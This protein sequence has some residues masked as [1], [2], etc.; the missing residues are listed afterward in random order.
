MKCWFDRHKS[1]IFWFYRYGVDVEIWAHEH[2]YERFW[3]LY[4][5][6]VKNGST[7]HPYTNPKAPIHI[8]TGA[9]GNKEGRAPFKIKVPAWSAFHSNVGERREENIDFISFKM[10]LSLHPT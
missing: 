1:E 9:A 10:L 3:P 8:V 5:Y 6:K 2:S 4:D 7:E